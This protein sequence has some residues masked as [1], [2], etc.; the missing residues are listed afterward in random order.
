M[1]SPSY[2][3]AVVAAGLPLIGFAA[4][5]GWWMVVFGGLVLL[6]GLFGWAAE[7]LSE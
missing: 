5:Y 4:L 7:P 2:Y 1:P 6:A 3:P